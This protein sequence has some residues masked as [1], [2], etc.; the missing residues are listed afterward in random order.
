[1]PRLEVVMT[2]LVLNA[3]IVDFLTFDLQKIEIKIKKI[4]N[5]GMEVGVN[6]H[7]TYREGGGG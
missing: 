2:S 7:N 6:A 1:M 3:F 4:K 5:H